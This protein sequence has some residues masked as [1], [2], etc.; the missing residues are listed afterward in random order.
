MF[1]YYLN[2]IYIIQYLF[3]NCF[4]INNKDNNNFKCFIQMIKV[5]LLLLLYSPFVCP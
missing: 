1:L 3:K 5:L 2:I 4:Y